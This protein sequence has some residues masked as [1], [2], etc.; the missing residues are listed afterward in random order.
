MF[1]SPQSISERRRGIALTA[2]GALGFS[3]IIIFTRLIQGIPAPSIAFFRALSSFLFFSILRFRSSKNPQIRHDRCAI[4][5]LIGLGTAVGATG[6]FY[7][8][9]V[10]HTTAAN[11]VLLN[12]TAVIY[13]SLLA[14]Y[15]LK[16]A[17]SRYTWISL[18]LAMIGIVCIANP[19]ELELHS[20]AFWGVAAAALSGITYTMVMLLS[21]LLRDQ[22]SG[23]VQIWWSTGIA[24]LLALP[25]AF[26][27]SW[28]VLVQNLPL[29]VALG[30][31]AQGIPYLLYFLGLQR[32]DAQIVSIVALLEPVGGILI[33]IV[34]YH[35]IPGAVGLAGIV[36]IFASIALVS[37]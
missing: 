31:L 35:E 4:P 29:L 19:A 11:A 3:T 27:V 22:V 21:R 18:S 8:Y 16:E 6:M 25:W 14:P 2:A 28:E 23:I 10:Q 34:L 5:R 20:R 32:V 1:N 26:L 17:H 13:V 12:N 36:M 33:G 9:A 30:V 24:A 37:Q 7:V 15:L